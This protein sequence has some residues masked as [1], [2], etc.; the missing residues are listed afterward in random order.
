MSICIYI[1]SLIELDLV[2]VSCLINKKSC[3]IKPHR[4]HTDKHNLDFEISVLDTEDN[5]Q[6]CLKKM[7]VELTG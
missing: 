6:N 2:V 4:Q 5:V 1:H 3:E 7:Y